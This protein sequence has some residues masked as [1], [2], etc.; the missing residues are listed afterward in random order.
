MTT[1]EHLIILRDAGSLIWIN[2]RYG[3]TYAVDRESLD[4]DL[5]ESIPVLHLGQP[6]GIKAIIDSYAPGTWRVV[7]LWADLL[8]TEVR[9]RQRGTSDIAE[10]LEVW[11]QTP[12]LVN[13]S[14]RIDTTQHSPHTVAARIQASVL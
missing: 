6:E 4:R 7:E 9:L 2:E 5:S 3:A 12:P 13:A 10:R 1:H 14:L 8:A 11:S